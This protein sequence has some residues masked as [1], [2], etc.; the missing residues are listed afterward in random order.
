MCIRDSFKLGLGAFTDFSQ[1]DRLA[2]LPLATRRIDFLGMHLGILYSNREVHPDRQ[3]AADEDGLGFSIAVGIRYSHGR[4]E[5]LG[6]LVPEQYDPP[7]VTNCG[8][9]AVP[10]GCLRVA[11]KVNEIGINLGAKV[12]F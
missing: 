1:V 7:A 11:T 5:T 10:D 6:L 12:A 8:N 2:R 9:P 4:G 3:T